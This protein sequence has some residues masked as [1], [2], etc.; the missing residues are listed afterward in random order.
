MSTKKIVVC[1]A[2]LVSCVGGAYPQAVAYLPQVG[3]GTAGGTTL[4]TT[5]IVFN[6][7]DNPVQ[8]KLRLTNDAGQ[9]FLITMADVGT[10]DEFN[11]S[12][13]PGE[14]RLLQ[15]EGSG[16]VA[17]GAARVESAVPVGVSAIFSLYDGQNFRT[18]AGFGTSEPLTNFF[19]PVDTS[20]SFNTGLALFNPGTAEASLTF[21]LRNADGTVA[22]TRTQ[23]LGAGQHVARFVVGEGELFPTVSNFR[24]S[25]EV[26]STQPLSAATL[27]QNANP[28][29][30]TSLPVVSK[31]STATS[32]NLP[33]VANGVDTITGLSMRTTF[34]VF[35]ISPNPANVTFSVRKPDGTAFPVTIAGVAN[36]TDTFTR[37]LAPGAS[38]ILQTDGS[39]PLSVG[40]A[41]VTSDVP[42]GV[43]GIFS[44]FN[45][46]S[47]LTEAGVGSSVNRTDFSLPVD[48]TSGFD[49]G[50][51][52][53]NPGDAAVTVTVLL[54]DAAGNRIGESIPLVLQPK[55]QTAKFVTE[56]FPGRTNFRGSISVHSTAD[57]AAIT[58][59]QNAAPLSY[60]TLPVVV[61][62][63]RGV[64]AA[65]APLLSATRTGVNGTANQTVDSSL[66]AGYRLSGIIGGKVQ[67]IESVYAK[68]DAG[69]FFAGTIDHSTGRYTVIV[70]PGVYNVGVCYIPRKTGV[71]LP[72]LTFSSPP[73]TVTGETSANLDIN[74]PDLRV[75]RGTVSGLDQLP[76]NGGVSVVFTGQQGSA[77]QTIPLGADGAYELQLPQGS[78]VASL[79]VTNIATPVQPAMTAYNLATITVA[80][81]AVTANFTVP[82]S[83]QV[84]G[85]VRMADS[86]AIPAN[87]MV[88]AI[89]ADVPTDFTAFSCNASAGG[90][91]AVADATGN[92]T[93]LLSN[94]RSYKL[95]VTLPVATG[96]TAVYDSGRTIQTLSGNRVEDFLVP[97]LPA[98]VTVT[99]KVTDFRGQA[100]PNAG[101]EIFS[102]QIT[103]APGVSFSSSVTTDAAGGYSVP[104]PNGS[105]YRMMFTPVFV[106]P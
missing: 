66:N 40:A 88:T 57:I 24:G 14:T 16:S 22:D 96:G 98:A 102:D 91:T 23:T 30:Y 65:D 60:T 90:S 72:I 11:L 97:V 51:A 2:V 67:T 69:E 76:A 61:G 59:R 87:T 95:I 84:T 56:L 6:P 85:R 100:V 54:L 38:A 55:A 71:N 105:N 19:V 89:A 78:Y 74:Y 5:F 46:A 48:A 53:Y 64:L 43:A 42:I 82:I 4:K 34:L 63:S 26:S 99:G 32:F 31:T 94:A 101:V 37:A 10:T 92:Y 104:V 35:N 77:G 81:T 49:T 8:V 20:G 79:F 75:V 3:N 17:A 1:L 93:L 58:L 7:T 106:T 47:F 52:F 13:A 12:L 70:P 33:Q 27:R 103:G 86:S 80:G 73:V 83:S 9:P 36:N 39:G 68:N 15:S 45:G 50:V 62:G 28:L 18:E 29:S 25:A 44:L 41:A 21:T